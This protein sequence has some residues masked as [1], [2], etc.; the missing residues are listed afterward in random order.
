MIKAIVF[1]LGGVVFKSD[2]GS[3]ET[4]EVLA[5]EL[6]IE[7]DKLHNFWFKRKEAMITGKMSEDRY[8]TDLIRELHLKISLEE[9]KKL[10]R[11]YNIIDE[12]MENIIYSLKKKYSIFALTNDVAEWIDF[13]I[14]NF[15]LNDSFN[16]IISS[17]DLGL[18]KPDPKIYKYLVKR[19][20]LNPE[21]IIFIDNREENIEP[22]LRLGI[23]AFHFTTPDN[24]RNWLKSEKIL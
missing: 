2:T 13:R 5:E 18:A 12:N 8:F 17:S 15:K 19:L 23:K 20:N 10:I 6:N 22:A 3:F 11:S 7:A 9:I 24:F 4:R 1:D 14:K 21:E 16:F